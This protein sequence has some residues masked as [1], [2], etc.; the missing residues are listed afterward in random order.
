MQTELLLVSDYFHTI[1]I[2]DVE[3]SNS[4]ERAM[5]LKCAFNKVFLVNHLRDILIVAA[6]GYV[7]V[8]L[9]VAYAR[10]RDFCFPLAINNAHVVGQ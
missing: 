8:T 10:N 9:I 7:V 1:R 3:L 5:K 6:K 2:R 4:M